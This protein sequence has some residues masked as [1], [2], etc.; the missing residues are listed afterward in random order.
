MRKDICL[1]CRQRPKRK[2]YQFC[3]HR[4]TN[5]A[6]K[7][8]PQLM[9]VPKGH[10]FYENVKKMFAKQWND[11]RQ[12]LPTIAKIYLITW[13]AYQ[14][15]SFE[16]YRGKVARMRKIGKGKPKEVKCFRSEKRACSLGD[17]KPYRLCRKYNCR[18][19]PAIRT[20]LKSSLDYKRQMVKKYAT[21]GV[22]FGGGLYMAPSSN[23]AFQYAENLSGGSKYL[24]VLVTRTVLGKMQF[25]KN[26]QHRRLSP[27]KGYDSVKARAQGGPLEYITYHKDAVRPAYLLMISKRK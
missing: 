5:L 6:A 2:D 20:A 14:R 27:D 16:K 26:E 3:S 10:V 8:A 4:C 21:T 9:R 17:K 13:T 7:K 23:K 1:V 11:K 25:L 12:H 24:T 18:L 19:C 15:T 22:R